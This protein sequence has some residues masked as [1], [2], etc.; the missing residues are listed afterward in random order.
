MRTLRG[1]PLLGSV[2]LWRRD[3]LELQRRLLAE[4]GDIGAF[5]NWARP[6]STDRKPTVTSGG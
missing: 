3:R 4:C 5:R 2:G 6:G 1:T